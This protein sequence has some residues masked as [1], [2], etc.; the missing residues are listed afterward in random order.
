MVAAFLA[1]SVKIPVGVLD[2]VG[3]LRRGLPQQV[4]LTRGGGIQIATGTGRG[5][6][7]IPG[8]GVGDD[9]VA[10]QCGRPEMAIRRGHALSLILFSFVSFAA[11]YIWIGIE[12]HVAADI[13]VSV[14][15]T[16]VIL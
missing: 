11:V 13:T 1:V 4:H 2:T 6:S 14:L 5:I 16:Q 7:I 9:E 15:Q 10:A 8:L 3:H 12:T